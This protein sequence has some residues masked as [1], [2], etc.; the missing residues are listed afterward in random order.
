M[1][2]ELAKVRERGTQP[3]CMGSCSQGELAALLRNGCCPKVILAAVKGIDY[4][5]VRV[6]AGEQSGGCAS[7]WVRDDGGVDQRESDD[8]SG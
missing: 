5:E 4:R 8:G 1:W 7:V 3:S 6:E 2:L